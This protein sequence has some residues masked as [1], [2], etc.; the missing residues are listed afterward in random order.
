MSALTVESLCFTINRNPVLQD[1]RLT[2]NAGETWSILGPN[3]AGKSTLLKCLLR[4]YRDW[5]G[6]VAVFGKD[7]KTYTQKD[8]ARR[9]A[10]VPQ[11]GGNQGFPYTVREFVRM[12][13]YPYAG[14]FGAQHGDDSKVVDASLARADVVQFAHRTLDTLSGG[15]R[16]KVFV[17]AAL[18]QEADILLLD[19]PAAF[20]DYR[21]QFEIAEILRSLSAQEGK[22][23][24]S[25][26]HD[27]NAA[28]FTGGHVLALR[29]GEVVFSGLAKSLDNEKILTSIFNTSF[30]FIDDPV[31]GQ[32]I[33]APQTAATAGG[34]L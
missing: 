10:Y 2:V 19:E 15:E 12:G 22:T 6:R 11:A 17:A 5:R 34:S 9:I 23:V 24:I 16:Q 32:K 1:I 28:L 21:H 7:L 25:V 8:L 4:I 13:R 14:V 27:V 20:L 3:G 18:A 33:V 29:E 26:T 30:R 31:T